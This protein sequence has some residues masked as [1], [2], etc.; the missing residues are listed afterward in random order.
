MQRFA[1]TNHRG[2]AS[3]KQHLI[4]TDLSAMRGF[5]LLLPS[6]LLLTVQASPLEKRNVFGPKCYTMNSTFCSSIGYNKT[7]ISPSDGPLVESVLRSFQPLVDSGCSHE[8]KPFLCF[9]HL[10]I[11]IESE[12]ETEPNVVITPCRSMCKRVESK[13]RLLLKAAGL[14][15]PKTLNCTQYGDEPCSSIPCP[16]PTPKICEKCEVKRKTSVGFN[17][18]CKSGSKDKRLCKWKE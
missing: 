4:Y 13:C 11:C 6:V 1:K 12:K 15:W 14:S 3:F 18:M 8:L 9:A 10:P 5:F 7:N 17:K 16:P 2:K